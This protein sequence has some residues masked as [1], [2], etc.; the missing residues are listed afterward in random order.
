[1]KP[2]LFVGVLLGGW[3]CGVAPAYAQRQTYLIPPKD[4]D[5]EI[6]TDL[7]S[8]YAALD[9][10]APPKNQMFLF[11]P[12]T[13][14]T[15][16]FQQQLSNTAA[17]LGFHVIS[18]NYPND[19]AVNRDLCVGPDADL[20]CYAKVRLEIKDGIDRTPLL[21][22]TRANSIENR[23]IKL[24]VYLRGR[25]PD[26]GWGQYLTNDNTIN[27]SSIVVS[28]HSQGGGHAGIIGRY[29]LVARVVMFAAMDYSGREMKAAN[30]IAMP[31]STP[32]ATPGER[33]YGFSHQRDE[34]VNFAILSTQ[35]WPAYGMNAFGPVVN[36]DDTAP[37]YSNTNSL[38]SNL[39]TPTG[40]YHGSVAVDRNLALEADGTPVYKPVW[41]YLLSNTTQDDGPPAIASV[42]I[43]KKGKPVDHLVAGAKAKKFRI[44]LAGSG[45][46][47][48]SKA[49][50]DGTEAGTALTSSTELTV[51]LPFK[52]V[53]D[54]GVIT[55]QVR[56]TDGQVSNILRIEV[57]DE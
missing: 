53:P 57:R 11:F 49:L 43:L 48:G 23:L 50:I 5:S 55:V 18:L 2:F 27:W 6:T 12:G 29:H 37:P 3:I 22:I 20:D 8:H 30:W 34:A 21:N 36:V 14:G 17:D 25:F 51:K 31:D 46:V 42:Q 33:F 39:N 15:P 35:V 26:D 38:T 16:F 40:N 44:N 4:T 19:R 28:G 9:K 10:S 54:A 41:E 56:N 32:N 1:M 45:F 7:E 47:V 24:L 13:G 52:K